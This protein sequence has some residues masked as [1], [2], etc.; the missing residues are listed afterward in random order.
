MK[1]AQYGLITTIFFILIFI[2]A[3]WGSCAGLLEIHFIDVGQAD[4]IVIRSPSGETILVDAAS[5]S[6]AYR[7]KNYLQKLGISTIE[8]VIIT[9]MHPDH[10]GGVFCIL[11]EFRVKTIYDN[12]M[13]L[14]GNVF[15]EEYHSILRNL[16][17]KREI[18]LGGSHLTYGVLKIQVLSPFKP[19]A[20]DLN[21]DSIVTRVCYGNTAFLL[22]ADLTKAGE[23]RLLST[24]EN[25][26]SQVLKVG[27]HGACD[28][29]SDRFLERVKPTIAVITVGEKNRWG[30]PCP[31]TLKKLKTKGIQIFRTD[32]SGT[33]IIRSD[34]K[35]ITVATDQ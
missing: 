4:S 5:M 35:R 29:T 19:L 34:G 14:A 26:Q 18:L 12:G 20:G 13:I 3:T 22:A 32:T 28:A 31:E 24:K 30:H 17:I 6:S 7:V 8:G 27:H 21:T 33:V 10:V 1:K 2:V 25:I 9:H 11:P 15:W 16:G 23:N